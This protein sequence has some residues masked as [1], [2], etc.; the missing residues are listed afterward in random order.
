M[1][2][3]DPDA[4]QAL[5]QVVHRVLCLPGSTPYARYSQRHRDTDARL[6]GLVL[7]GMGEAGFS[8]ASKE[9]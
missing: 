8:F 9:N 5:A 4:V 1:T 7:A 2:T 6:A 3:P